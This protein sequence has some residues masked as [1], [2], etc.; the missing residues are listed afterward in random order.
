MTKDSFGDVQPDLPG[1][2]VPI[3]DGS[4]T[5]PEPGFTTR[6]EMRRRADGGADLKADLAHFLPDDDHTL[7][8]IL[9]ASGL[10]RLEADGRTWELEVGEESDGT[11]RAGALPEDE[12]RRWR[13]SWSV[14]GAARWEP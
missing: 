5:A 13:L 6:F 2:V 9:A 10:K 11:M 12:N 4:I 3:R 1:A 7:L 14:L 8:A